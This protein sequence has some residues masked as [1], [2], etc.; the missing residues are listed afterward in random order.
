MFLP[1]PGFVRY[2]VSRLNG[3]V[4]LFLDYHD[5]NFTCYLLFWIF[6]DG[7]SAYAVPTA[8]TYHVFRGCIL[9]LLLVQRVLRKAKNQR[10]VIHKSIIA[11]QNSGTFEPRSSSSS[12]NS[13]RHHVGL[14]YPPSHPPTQGGRYPNDVECWCAYWYSQQ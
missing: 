7:R 8:Y 4:L 12:T 2:I 10:L 3:L 11:L 5:S 14:C 9:P 13:I 6:W 1:M